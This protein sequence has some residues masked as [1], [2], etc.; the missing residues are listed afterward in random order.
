ML[1]AGK[2]AIGNSTGLT[3]SSSAINLHWVLGEAAFTSQHESSIAEDYCPVDCWVGGSRMIYIYLIMYIMYN[4]NYNIRI[5][6]I[7]HFLKCTG[8]WFPACR[9]HGHPQLFH[10][11]KAM[12]PETLHLR[13]GKLTIV[14]KPASLTSMPRHLS[15]TA[16]AMEMA[17]ELH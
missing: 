16:L 17:A 13:K 1:A 6:I 2:G 15:S 8:Y 4:Y 11:R 10:S 3:W 12:E 7:V 14:C 5:H 9:Y